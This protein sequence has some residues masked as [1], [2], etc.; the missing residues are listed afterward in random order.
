M[1]F[2]KKALALLLSLC[3]VLSLAACGGREE[4]EDR[5]EPP[6]RTEQG[7][8]LDRPE[9]ESEEE[10][11]AMLMPLS[12]YLQQEGLHILYIC[13]SDIGKSTSPKSILAF[14]DGVLIWG[15][16]DKTFGDLSKM[17]DE[18][19]AEEVRAA[20]DVV[21]DCPYSLYVVTDST[22]NNVAK[23]CLALYRAG[24]GVT[25]YSVTFRQTAGT[26]YESQYAGY[27]NDSGSYLVARCASS[28]AVPPY[29]FDG[30]D[31]QG[32]AV[33]PDKEEIFGWFN[34]YRSVQLYDGT[35]IHPPESMDE[36][37][38]DHALSGAGA[39]S[40]EDIK[41]SGQLPFMDAK[42]EIGPTVRLAL[43]LD[44]YGRIDGSGGMVLGSVDLVDNRLVIYPG[45]MAN[46]S[47][48]SAFYTLRNPSDAAVN[49]EDAELLLAQYFFAVG[50]FETS[51]GALTGFEDARA[52]WGDPSGVCLIWAD[53]FETAEDVYYWES[54]DFYLICTDGRVNGDYLLYTSKTL[55]GENGVK[56][57]LLD[58]LS[59]S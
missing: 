46:V 1:K 12:L 38:T 8:V 43:D 35:V 23:E 34:A 56:G 59:F 58:S 27:G 29:A 13:G 16:V 20:E 37:V 17:S 51:A 36:R 47:V 15:S 49:T 45:E 2:W 31:A 9:E 30:V 44:S 7:D 55:L 3:V 41:I 50:S 32:V 52:V 5:T 6:A 11:L 48:G 33:D 26:V 22:G 18:E 14:E 57:M 39:L 25:T 24:S 40:V 19:I 42:G 10:P 21:E 4:K 53:N 54:E 28:P